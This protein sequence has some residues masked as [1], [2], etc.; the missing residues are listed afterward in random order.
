MQLLIYQLHHTVHIII[1]D[2]MSLLI[3]RLIACL[4]SYIMGYE[5]CYEDLLVYGITRNLI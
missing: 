2:R 4:S 3:K 5:E 1:I